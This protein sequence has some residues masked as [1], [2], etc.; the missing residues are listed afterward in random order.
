MFTMV[1]P[2]AITGDGIGQASRSVAGKG[3]FH[4]NLPKIKRARRA[5]WHL[6]VYTI[7]EN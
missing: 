2:L 6:I 7:E 4:P 1:S 5:V 3:D